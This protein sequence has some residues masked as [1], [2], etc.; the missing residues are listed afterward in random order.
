METCPVDTAPCNEI[1][2]RTLGRSRPRFRSHP[3]QNVISPSG[4]LHVLG[5]MLENC[6][7]CPPFSLTSMGGSSVI[8][9]LQ[10]EK[11]KLRGCKTLIQRYTVV[12]DLWALPS[13]HAAPS[14]WFPHLQNGHSCDSIMFSS[15]PHNS[16]YPEGACLNVSPLSISLPFSVCYFS[17]KLF[18]GGQ[19]KM[20][21]QEDP[22]PTAS[23]GHPKST[24]T[25]G[26][27][28]SEKDQKGS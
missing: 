6:H 4:I 5:T 25:Y 1:V 14:P 9:I 12:R 7:M 24:S 3:W 13:C 16:V 10:I 11:W 18:P 26:T 22:E 19:F 21:A 23:H 15:P 2:H 8:H 28:N 17:K 20:A 27:V